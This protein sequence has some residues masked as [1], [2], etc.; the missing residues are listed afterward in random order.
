LIHGLLRD[1]DWETTGRIAALMG[2][3]KVERH[4]T[5]NHRFSR[6]QFV[7]RYR[8]AFDRPLSLPETS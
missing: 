4:G 3:F 7:E 1:L 8:A 5:Q 6:D 2:A